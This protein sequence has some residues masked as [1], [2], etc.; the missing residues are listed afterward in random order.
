LFNDN[1]TVLIPIKPYWK[2]GFFG[3]ALL[4]TSFGNFS[5]QPSL[6][7]NTAYYAIKRRVHEVHAPCQW[8]EN[9]Y[10]E[11]CPAFENVRG[12]FYC[13]NGGIT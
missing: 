11:K 7:G 10:G 5:E 3:G 4:G 13:A 1:N 8:L 6:K 2:S 12:N 9:C